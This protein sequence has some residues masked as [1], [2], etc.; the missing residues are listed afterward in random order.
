MNPTYGE[1]KQTRMPEFGA[2]KGLLQGPSKGNI[3]LMLKRPKLPK[4]F[5]GRVL[6]AKSEVRATG[7]VT[8]F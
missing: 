7:Y 6:K 4:G 3:W 1:A 8:S 2:E 5:Q